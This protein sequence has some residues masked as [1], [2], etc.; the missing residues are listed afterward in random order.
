MPL[1]SRVCRCAVTRGGRGGD[2]SRSATE[3][4]VLNGGLDPGDTERCKVWSEESLGGG[5]VLTGD[6]DRC[7][8]DAGAR[9][10]GESPGGGMVL[11]PG[12]GVLLS[13]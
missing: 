4:H 3:D 1:C 7:R 12:G 8:V 11:S 13:R 10:P 9:F 6:S 5:E 2:T